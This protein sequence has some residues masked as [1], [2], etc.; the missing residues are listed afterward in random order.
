MQ[1]REQGQRETGHHRSPDHPH[2]GAPQRLPCCLGLF[3]TLPYGND[4]V[5]ERQCPG[6]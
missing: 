1:I 4:E 2:V 6:Y 3:V 5:Y